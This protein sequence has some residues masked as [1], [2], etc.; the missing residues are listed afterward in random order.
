[1]TRWLPAGEESG[2][3]GP[4][5]GTEGVDVDVAGVRADEGHGNQL[6]AA[7]G[8]VGVGRVG[9][10]LGVADRGGDRLH[11]ATGGAALQGGRERVVG[12]VPLLLGEGQPAQQLGEVVEGPGDLAVVRRDARPG[13]RSPGPEPAGEGAAVHGRAVP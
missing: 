4:H 2:A 12:V 11:R 6:A 10:G 3:E 1:M 5:G 13:S 9:L 8:P 7:A